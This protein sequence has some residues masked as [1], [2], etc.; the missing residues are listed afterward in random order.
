MFL[1]GL[2][3]EDD[4]PATDW[5][6]SGGRPICAFGLVDDAD[7]PDAN[8]SLMKYGPYSMRW[9]AKRLLPLLVVGAFA[10]TAAL[11]GV[12]FS[13]QADTPNPAPG[14][15]GNAFDVLLTNTGPSPINIAAYVFGVATTDTD[16]TFTE[17]DVSTVVSPYIFAG[18]SFVA[19]FLGGIT[20]IPAPVGLPPLPAQVLLASDVGNNP[21]SFTT[22]AAGRTVDLGRV[23]FNVAPNAVVQGF[24]V[25]FIMTLFPNPPGGYADNN[26]SDE[27]GNA[28]DIDTFQSAS[29]N[30]AAAVAGIDGPYQVRYA[31]NLTAGESY[32]DIMND[33]FNGDPLTGPGGGSAGNIC[34]NVYAFDANDEQL[35]SCCSCLVTPNAAVSLGVKADLTSN[36]LT[37]TK[38]GSVTVKLV[39]TLAGA[40]GTGTGSVCNGSAAAVT[41]ANAVSGMVAWGTTLQPAPGSTTAF[42]TTETPFAPA[43]LGTDDAASIFLQVRLHPRQWQ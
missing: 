18:N 33:G 5:Q 22:V 7:G 43:S 12:T 14:S 39:A 26:L 41:T 8:G 35:V 3:G 34:V 31:A 4:G 37:G 13:I 29:F 25:S 16:I 28:I 15:T 27:N 21:S 23:L 30:V 9:L 20:D 42:V 36:T 38:P 19:D 2:A 6:A 10:S 11:A 17:A 32:I 40:G 24:T 1:R